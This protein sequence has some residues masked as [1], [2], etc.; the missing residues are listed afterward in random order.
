MIHGHAPP[1]TGADYAQIFMGRNMRVTTAV[2]EPGADA[3]LL[4]GLGLPGFVARSRKQNEATW[5][6]SL[7]LALPPLQPASFAEGA[8]TDYSSI[9]NTR[10]KKNAI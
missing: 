8:S 9:K 6:L 7:T 5:F 1:P 10:G 4:A 2:P 3:M